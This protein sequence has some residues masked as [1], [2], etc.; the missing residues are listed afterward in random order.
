VISLHRKA[1][2]FLKVGS[3]PYGK[4]RHLTKE[5]ITMLKQTEKMMIQDLRR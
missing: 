4:Y 2:G 1:I 5:E 3:L